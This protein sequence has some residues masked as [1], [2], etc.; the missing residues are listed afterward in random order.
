MFYC[1]ADVKFLVF[2]HHLHVL[3]EVEVA[4]KKK[5]IEYFRLDG[6]TSQNDRHSGVKRFQGTSSCRVALLSITAG[7]VGLTLTA[8][9]HVVFA[10]LYW[11]PA[12]ILQAEDRVHRIGQTNCVTVAYIIGNNTLDDVMWPLLQRKLRVVGSAL[13]GKAD[14]ME[15]GGV[16][17]K[18][19]KNSFKIAPPKPER[20]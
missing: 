14:E 19:G 7:G 6:K 11:N 20:W 13:D 15:F 9:D 2:A 17:G 3:N 16:S 8:A 18:K 5:K 12:Q 1:Q 4:L 10:E